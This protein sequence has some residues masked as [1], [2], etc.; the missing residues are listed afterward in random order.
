[1]RSLVERQSQ[2]RD[3]VCT[4]LGE[5]APPLVLSPTPAADE[6]S[7]T[8]A[9]IRFELLQR[10]ESAPDDVWDALEWSLLSTRQHELQHLAAIWKI[11]LNWDH[12]PTDLHATRTPGVPLHPA[13]R[14][15]ESH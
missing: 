15:E 7:E 13:D 1:V 8:L 9:T 10:L 2:F 11:A 12:V 3:T 5:E 14:L 6:L 4:S